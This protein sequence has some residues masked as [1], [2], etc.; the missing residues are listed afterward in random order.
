M[1]GDDAQP[2]KTISKTNM[3]KMLEEM[4]ILHKKAE[5]LTVDS[6][7]TALNAGFEPR[8]MDR[9]GV[10]LYTF[11]NVP[12]SEM[13]SMVLAVGHPDTGFFQVP[14]LKIAGGKGADAVDVMVSGSIDE[15]GKATKYPEAK[16]MTE[17]SQDIFHVGMENANRVYG[18]ALFPKS[19]FIGDWILV[20][21]QCSGYSTS[22][23]FN[24]ARPVYHICVNGFALDRQIVGRHSYRGM[25]ESPSYSPIMFPS[26]DGERYLKASD[27]VG[28]KQIK[29]QEKKGV[30]A[31]LTF[32]A[33]Q[34]EEPRRMREPGVLYCMS[35]FR[36]AESK[37]VDLES[38]MRGGEPT[39]GRIGLEVGG[40]SNVRY[41]SIEGNITSVDGMLAM[42]MLGVDCKAPVGDI[43]LAIEN[44]LK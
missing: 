18:V 36:G 27:F 8:T 19:E 39:V 1:I 24:M 30:Y 32:C 2:K 11:S 28:N 38:T 26:E 17:A 10:K 20:G 13:H 21:G 25:G 22:R 33:G 40:K 42:H 3:Y 12:V 16:K 29:A 14:V 43:K 41:S 7:L 31:G 6:E 5:F 9:D 44:L 35:S 4:A 15:K 37:G 34:F 23:S